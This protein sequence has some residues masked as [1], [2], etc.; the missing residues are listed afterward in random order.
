LSPGHQVSGFQGRDGA[1]ELGVRASSSAAVGLVRR[2]GGRLGALGGSSFQR[3]SLHSPG[4]E[5]VPKRRA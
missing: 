3:D 4:A 5:L 2:E 1:A